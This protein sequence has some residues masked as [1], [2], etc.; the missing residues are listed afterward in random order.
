[1]CHMDNSKKEPRL[2]EYELDA[3]SYEKSRSQVA[4]IRNELNKIPKNY[5]DYNSTLGNVLVFGG[6]LV[7]FFLK[8]WVVFIIC[9]I[10]GLIVAEIEITNKKREEEKKNEIKKRNFEN[11]LQ[12][13]KNKILPFEE[14]SVD[15]YRNYLNNFHKENLYKKHSGS[16]KFE[17]SLSEFSSLIDE[18]DE[19]NKKLIFKHIYTYEYSS[20]LSSRLISHS[21]QKNAKQHFASFKN[22][23]TKPSE[24]NSQNKNITNFAEISEHNFDKKENEENTFLSDMLN[25][26]ND[27][28]D[29]ANNST[30][31][32]KNIINTIDVISPYKKYSTPR[33]IDWE[34][35]NKNKAVTGMRGEEIVMEIEQNYLKSIDRE[36][37]AVK[38]RHASK[39]DGDGLG[40]DILSFFLDGQEKYIEV[41]SSKNSNSNSFN[42]T[43]NELDFMKENKDNYQIYRLFNVGN[44]DGEF[45]TL[46]IDT[47]SDILNYKKIIPSQY[48]VKM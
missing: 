22:I 18:V 30:T 32:N 21:Y 26:F 27:E 44:T 28:I 2:E 8:S 10:A 45:P 23:D 7:G 11:E 24:S 14:N 20:Y 31:E 17:H 25:I 15:Y 5:Y 1:M 19:I 40:Y 42:I 39:T 47:A 16:E 4:T 3:N 29:N 46:K 43:D 48:L 33:K 6:I 41:K 12:L 37:L 34:S 35:I 38:V 36:D 9:F 13:I